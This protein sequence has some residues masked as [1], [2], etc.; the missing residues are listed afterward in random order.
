MQE[1]VE[2]IARYI[3]TKPEE[4][5]ATEVEVDDS[6]T[7]IQLTV[8][9]EDLGRII[10][11]RGAIAKNIRTVLRAVSLKKDTNYTLKIIEND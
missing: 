4:V 2:Y 6:M 8:A 9:E 3:V 10:G 5:S 7:E 1:L 11:R